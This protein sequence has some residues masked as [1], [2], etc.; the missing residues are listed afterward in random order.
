MIRVTALAFTCQIFLTASCR[1]N[2]K[3]S[4]SS[5][6][7]ICVRWVLSK[8]LCALRRMPKISCSTDTDPCLPREKLEESLQL[9]FNAQRNENCISSR[10]LPFVSGTQSTT[11]TRVKA[12]TTMYERKVPAQKT[13]DCIS[14][15]ASKS[16]LKHKGV[17]WT[18]N[19]QHSRLA[20]SS[21]SLLW[22]KMSASWPVLRCFRRDSW[23]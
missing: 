21:S 14:F 7:T 2:R 3:N 19:L 8:N 13:K 16:E 9:M 5:P 6:R 18:V 10:V 4:W 12:L 15:H 23:C 20:S 11:K 17:V 1:I 22:R